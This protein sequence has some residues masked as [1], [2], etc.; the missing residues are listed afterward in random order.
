MFRKTLAFLAL[1]VVPLWAA[2]AASTGEAEGGDGNSCVDCH[3]DDGFLVTNKKLYDY[4]QQWSRSVHH[5]EAVSCED[6]HGGDPGSP[7]KATAH[8]KGVGAADPASGIHFENVSDTCGTCH[9]EIL[10]G[11][12]KSSHFEHVSKKKGEE[13]G[14]T[15]VTC[16]GS[17]DSEVLDVRTVSAACE[18]C[19]N[20]KTDNH[21][22]TP[23]KAQDALN[24]F[25]SIHRFYRY[26][27]IRAE[28]EEARLFIQQIEPL[29]EQLAVTWHTFDLD[30]IDGETSAVIKLLKEKRDEIRGRR[31]KAK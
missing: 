24:R 19:H 30:A 28:P 23:E 26:I 10:E 6:C 14:P 12:S 7:D 18:R 27:T 20:Q 22:D 11:F 3:A 17:I 13:Q 15:C 16:H 8:G 1:L 4:F 31:G 21:P 5:Q 29:M 9:D 2:T 25:L